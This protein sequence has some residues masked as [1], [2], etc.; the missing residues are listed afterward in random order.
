VVKDVLREILQ[1]EGPLSKEELID[2]VRKERYVKD[3]TI[4]VNLQD[5]NLFKHLS[6]G[7]YTLTD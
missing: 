5:A 4:V 1:N 7:L 3:N 2:K 6:N